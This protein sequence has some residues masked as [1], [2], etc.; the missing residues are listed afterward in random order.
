MIYIYILLNNGEY[1]NYNNDNFLLPV[2]QNLTINLSKSINLAKSFSILIKL[3]LDNLMLPQL[4]RK[5]VFILFIA[6]N[7]RSDDAEVIG[8]VKVIGN[9]HKN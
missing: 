1:I 2:P 8:K 4:D 9:Y 3:K 5:Y 7:E 6:E